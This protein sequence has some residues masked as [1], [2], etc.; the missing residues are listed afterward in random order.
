MDMIN[1]QG[2]ESK[3]EIRVELTR[4]L[5]PIV[6][7]VSSLESSILVQQDQLYINTLNSMNNFNTDDRVSS[8]TSNSN[9]N[10]DLKSRNPEYNMESK[11][12]D[13]IRNRNDSD[14]HNNLQGNAND[15]G[16]VKDTVRD[17]VSEA[18]LKEQVVGL[19]GALAHKLEKV[20]I[21]SKQ[22]R[23]VSPFLFYYF[24][25][26]SAFLSVNFV[27]GLL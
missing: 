7:A 27:V 19:L 26:F 24:F 11:T 1:L 9:C 3:R 2:L 15:L 17:A 18:Y 23:C 6:L 21:K 20:D 4:R 13:N 22:T 25:L 14:I 12:N 16:H 10:L 8:G 5:E